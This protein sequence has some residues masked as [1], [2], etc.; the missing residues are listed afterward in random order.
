MW[1]CF[2][3]LKVRRMTVAITTILVGTD[4][5]PASQA[6]MRWAA[7]LAFACQ[8]AVH[9]VYAWSPDQSE[10]R[11]PIAARQKRQAE[12]KLDEWC[13]PLRRARL[14]YKAEVVEGAPEGVLREEAE[15]IDPDLVVIGTRGRQG[16]VVLG[17]GAVAHGLVHR[18]PVP[19][20]VVPP[21]IATF[22]GGPVVVG[23]DGSDA[24]LVPLL[25]GAGLAGALRRPL[26]AVHG[27]GRA[28]TFGVEGW[29]QPD[30][31]PVQAHVTL[32]EEQHGRIP[33][34][35]VP[36]SPGPALDEVAEARDAPAVVVGGLRRG[37]LAELRLGHT[38]VLLVEHGARPVVIVP[39]RV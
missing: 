39:D 33:L 34:E 38:P 32:V 4:G 12:A 6:A 35:L 37:L 1:S 36:D 11:P 22:P 21:S 28:E 2:E 15:R 20:T 29:P 17:L 27:L 3:R 31:G 25:W 24:S 14:R 8:A 9:A 5:S 16:L 18:L 30:V 19:V 7:G 26:L 10:L 23:V 13:S